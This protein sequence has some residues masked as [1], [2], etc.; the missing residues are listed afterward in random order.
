MKRIEVRL[1][2]SVVAPLL[3]V[4]KS[5]V[6]DLHS[7]PAAPVSSPDPDAEFSDEWTRELVAA[8]SSDVETLLALF[9]GDFFTDGIVRFD[10]SNA[11]SIARACS[12][13]R[14]R[15]RERFLKGLSDESLEAGEV[16]ITKL[17]EGVRKAFTCY[18]FLATIQ[19]LIVQHLDE[20]IIGS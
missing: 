1:S 5:L 14:L 15:V 19:E 8:Q 6:D 3:D 10:Q 12:A 7:A 17:E 4:I 9:G 11:E 18:L 16:D 20:S 13:V 2:L